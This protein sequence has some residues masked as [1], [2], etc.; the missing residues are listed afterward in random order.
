MKK[1][2]KELSVLLIA[3]L[4]IASFPFSYA[5]SSVDDELTILFTHDLH[6]HY[7]PFDVVSKNQIIN[8]G[9]FARLKTAI[10]TEK[11]NSKNTIVVDAGDYSMGTLFQS[12][13]AD[14]SPQLRLLGQLGYDVVTL[15][16]HEYDFRADGLAKSLNSA[17]ASNEILP[18]IVQSNVSFPL[19]ENGQMT[20]SLTMLSDA[21]SSFPVKEYDIIEKNGLKIGVFGITG[22]DSASKAPM[23]EVV[24]T[25]P[26]EKAKEVV[27]IL[28]NVEKV[29]FILCLSHSGTDKDKDKSEDEILA[30]EV[31]EI[32]VIISGHSHSVMKKPIIIGSTIIGSTGEYGKNLGLIKMTKKNDKWS[33]NNYELKPI[34]DTYKEDAEV[35]KSINNYK[36]LVQSNYLDNFNLKFDQIIANTP[37]SFT[38]DDYFAK[39]HGEDTL[40]N[41]ISDSFIYAVQEFEGDDYEQVDVAIV[42]S[43]TIRGSFVEGNMKVSD[44]FNVSSLGIGADK[45]SGYPLISIYLTGKELKTACEVD[46]TIT[47]IMAN[48]QL[49]MSGLR[50]SFNPNRIPLNKVT[51]SILERE[52]GKLEE[53]EEDRMYR[54]VVGLYSAQMLSAVESKS[55]GI[56]SVLPKDKD[57]NNITNFED[58]IITNKSTKTELKEWL[59]IAMYAS[60]FEKKDGISIIPDYYNKLQGRKIVEDDTSIGAF[61]SSPNSIAQKI[62]FAVATIFIL[63]ICIIFKVKIRKKNKSEKI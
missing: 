21:M 63:L 11:S 54:V 8:M 32:N 20:N 62:Y 47:P 58:H 57:G 5:D 37:F 34:N 56:L 52:D 18:R 1:I 27:D 59:A 4:L 41:F 48:A 7:I 44:I 29:D 31:P 45:I 19:D 36:K 51:Y 22:K 33:L 28:K 35:L 42:P 50:F 2:K 3:L 9:G 39:T 38:P 60:S 30:K 25:D 46:A 61:L 55:K 40:G 10:D 14:E 16:N 53:I 6:D 23:S 12:I 49:Y 43:G 26:L 13:Y 24:F 17:K 15:G